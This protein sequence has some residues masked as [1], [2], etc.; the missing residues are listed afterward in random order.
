MPLGE[1][2]QTL[3]D[4][5]VPFLMG[6]AQAA[7]SFLLLYQEEAASSTATATGIVKVGSMLFCA[8]C[9]VSSTLNNI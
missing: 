7:A 6:E 2:Y 4:T 9:F 3:L 5:A 8:C 1:A